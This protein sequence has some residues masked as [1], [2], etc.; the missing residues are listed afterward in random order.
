LM[1]KSAT[2]ENLLVALLRESGERFVELYGIWAG[3]FAKPPQVVEE[4]SLER[5]LEADFRFKEQG[6]YRVSVVSQ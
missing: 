3:D 2:I 4:I 5:I 6:F 1:Q